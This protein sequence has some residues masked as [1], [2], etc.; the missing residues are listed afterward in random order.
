MIDA[1]AIL[2]TISNMIDKCNLKENKQ[3]LKNF[4]SIKIPATGISILCLIINII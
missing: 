3:C 4:L 1:N 2:V